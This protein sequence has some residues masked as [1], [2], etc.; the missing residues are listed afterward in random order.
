MFPVPL[1]EIQLTHGCGSKEIRLPVSHVLPLEL[2]HYLGIR[3][4][5]FHVFVWL[6]FGSLSQKRPGNLCF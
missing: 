3:N 4:A 1:V 6:S 2:E 5:C